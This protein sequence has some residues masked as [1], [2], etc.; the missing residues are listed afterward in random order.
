MIMR[1]TG[2]FGGRAVA[3]VLC[4]LGLASCSE[5]V[6]G[7]SD[8]QGGVWRL[9]SMETANGAFVPGDRNRFTVEFKA[10]GTVGVVADCNQCGGTYTLDGDKL[11]VGALACTLIACPTPEG[12]QFAALLDGTTSVDADD[13]ELEIES[14]DGTL[15]FTR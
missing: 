6:T 15:E 1:E 12:Q 9:E 7:P 8:I 5:D 4:V 11:T 10:D 2:R 13:D 14:A 3:L